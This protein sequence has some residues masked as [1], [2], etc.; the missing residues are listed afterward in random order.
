MIKK[1]NKLIIKSNQYNHKAILLVE[2]VLSLVY[3]QIHS[4]VH[5]NVQ[6]LLDIYILNA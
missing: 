3:I 4:Y 1:I 5:A 6:D 2:Y